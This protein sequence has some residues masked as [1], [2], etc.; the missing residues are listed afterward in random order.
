MPRAWPSG[1][2]TAV[3]P[4]IHEESIRN[5]RFGYELIHGFIQYVSQRGYLTDEPTESI[6][7]G[8]D[9]TGQRKRFTYSAS[10]IAPSNV[11]TRTM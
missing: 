6:R 9:L 10:C 8:S 11:L 3:A 7:R 2:S 1:R 5:A 4:G